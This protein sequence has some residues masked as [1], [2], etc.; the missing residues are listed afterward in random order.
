MIDATLFLIDEDQGVCPDG[1]PCGLDIAQ[2][3]GELRFQRVCS[4]IHELPGGDYDLFVGL[5]LIRYDIEF[6]DIGDAEERGAHPDIVYAA[7]AFW[8]DVRA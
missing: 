6:D 4:S 5:P 2:R 7:R 3:S 8:E 1:H